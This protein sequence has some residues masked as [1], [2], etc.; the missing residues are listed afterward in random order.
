MQDMKAWYAKLAKYLPDRIVNGLETS[1]LN[2]LQL[3]ERAQIR[4]AQR[5]GPPYRPSHRKIIIDITVSCNLHCINCDR[6][7]GEAQ[8]PSSDYMS[9]AQIEKFI[10]EGIAQ[11]RKW[12]EIALEGGEP[13]LHP[14][15]DNIIDLLVQYRRTFSPRTSIQLLTNGYGAQS[16]M[17]LNSL[18]QK[19][20][21]VINTR[22]TSRI[23]PHH[24]A[25][26]VA[27]CDTPEMASVDFSQG[28]FLPACYGLGLTQYGYY[29]HPICGG[30]DR[31]FGFDIGR[32]RL[33]SPSDSMQDQ[34]A[35]LCALC[36]YFRNRFLSE[37]E[38]ENQAMR[39]G[40]ISEISVSW[41]DAYSNYQKK[42]PVL[43][44]Y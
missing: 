44:L 32:K 18:R 39:Y 13:T 15:L 29:P 22:K 7:C 34:F 43:D 28:C 26:N 37:V 20:I 33:P 35:R 14:D 8:A 3:L 2:P 41:K 24:C 1:L 4:L 21:L 27:P 10:G 23:Q 9:V 6:S 11:G 17:R 38:P 40:G 30:I 16:R 25:F 5:S 36:G 12:E 31:V 42:A 19:N